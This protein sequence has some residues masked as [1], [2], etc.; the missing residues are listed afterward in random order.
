MNKR[1]EIL[2]GVAAIYAFISC[3]LAGCDI[4]RYIF[5]IPMEH[6]LLGGVA[7]IAVGVQVYRLICMG[8]DYIKERSGKE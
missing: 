3:G 1:K 4:L 2:I 7:G 6:T 8:G 5:K